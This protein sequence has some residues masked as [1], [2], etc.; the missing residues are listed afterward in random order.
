MLVDSSLVDTI[1]NIR[2]INATKSAGAGD[3]RVTFSVDALT[4]KELIVEL[5]LLC[6]WT[7]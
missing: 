7:D 2:G 5:T 1:A 3:A 4:A 6:G